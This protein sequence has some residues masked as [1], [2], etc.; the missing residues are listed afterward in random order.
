M[1]GLLVLANVICFKVLYCFHSSC[2]CLLLGFS[3]INMAC[4]PLLGRNMLCISQLKKWNQ[5]AQIVHN[6]ILDSLVYYNDQNSGYKLHFCYA[7]WFMLLFFILLFNFLHY[8]PTISALTVTVFIQVNCTRYI[9]SM[10][11]CPSNFYFNCWSVESW[12]FSFI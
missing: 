9:F 3:A 5:L 1:C 12:P 10:L 6:L 8:I 2:A 7:L 11:S 4:P